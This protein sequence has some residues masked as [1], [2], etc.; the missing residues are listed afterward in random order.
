[1]WRGRAPPSCEPMTSHQN[2]SPLELSHLTREV[3]TALELAIIALCPAELVE[4]LAVSAGLLD[5]VGELPI[6]SPAVAAMVPGLD[7]RAR[8][9]LRDWDAWRQKHGSA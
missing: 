3:K 6:D 4:R 2:K 5:A 9:A 7:A 1:M 8:T